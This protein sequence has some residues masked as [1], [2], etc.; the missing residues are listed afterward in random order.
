MPADT[1]TLT[2]KLGF[3]DD[4]PAELPMAAE[5]LRVQGVRVIGALTLGAFQATG[6]VPELVYL[7][8]FIRP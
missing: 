5:N 2:L 7:G 1:D 3:I 4:T 8:C 6:I